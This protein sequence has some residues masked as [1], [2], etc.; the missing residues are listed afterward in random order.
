[1]GINN[2]TC[3]NCG[4][5]NEDGDVFCRYCGK[6]LPNKE[7]IQ[8]KQEKQKRQLSI[9]S[10]F[11]TIVFV[12]SIV[13]FVIDYTNNRKAKENSTAE[14]S[15]LNDDSYETYSL[16]DI[17]FRIPD[18]YKEVDISEVGD[19]TL[20]FADKNASNIFLVIMMVNSNEKVIDEFVDET[21]VEVE[22]N[23]E[24]KFYT[25]TGTDGEITYGYL[26]EGRNFYMFSITGDDALS[27]LDT[28]KQK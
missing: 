16:G 22:Y 26:S 8:R 25:F 19:Y 2:Y 4:G 12:V 15:F 3:G 20:G 7:E 23:S 21:H 10:I 11:L 17:K 14:S 1:M 24:T 27:I 9:A 5:K 18:T 6:R 13:L 28:V